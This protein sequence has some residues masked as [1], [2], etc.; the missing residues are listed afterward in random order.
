MGSNFI[1]DDSFKAFSREDIQGMTSDEIHQCMAH[2]KKLIREARARGNDT[3]R[4][5][6][7]YCYL[8]N[9]S[10]ARTRYEFTG[11]RNSGSKNFNTPRGN[12]TPAD[13]GNRG[14][15]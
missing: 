15:S 11:P 5:E 1:S 7:E 12:R 9:E 6:V 13:R 10:Q 2:F 3:H 8:D 14:R 4:Y